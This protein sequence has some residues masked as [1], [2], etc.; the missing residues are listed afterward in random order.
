VAHPSRLRGVEVPEALVPLAIDEFP[1]LFVAAAL[2]AGETRVSGAAE[3]RLKESDRIGV[4]A[5]GLTALGI[6][7]EPQADGMLV[8]GGRLRS[9]TVDSHGDHR[10]AMS[11]AVAATCAE[12]PVKILDVANVATSFPGFVDIARE[13]GLDVDGEAGS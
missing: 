7:V 2:A 11:F 1:V 5:E 6:E 9:G 4:M 3:L 8:R 10:I 12:G 13:A